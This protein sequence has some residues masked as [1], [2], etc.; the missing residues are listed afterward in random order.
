MTPRNRQEIARKS[1]AFDKSSIAF[2][3]KSNGNYRKSI[4]IQQEVA[5]ISLA[6]DKKLILFDTKSNEKANAMK[7]IAFDTKSNGN[8]RKSIRD[9]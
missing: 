2:D 1:T 5:R 4:G 9:R 3:T 6:F 7:S 8:D